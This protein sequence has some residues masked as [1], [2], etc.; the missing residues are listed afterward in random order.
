[1]VKKEVHHMDELGRHVMEGHCGVGAVFSALE[2]K[3][4]KELFLFTN[5]ILFKHY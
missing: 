5:G 2:N 3:Y 4:L 1:M